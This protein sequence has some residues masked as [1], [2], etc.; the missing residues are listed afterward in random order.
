[1][2]NIVHSS[3]KHPQGRAF[4][5]R[6]AVRLGLNKFSWATHDGRFVKN[7]D[8]SRIDQAMVKAMN[9]IADALEKKTIAEFVEN[10]ESFKMLAAFGVDCAQGYYLGRPD[11]ALTALCPLKNAATRKIS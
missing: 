7:L 11:V 9:E 8:T 6:L 2:T 1:M 5:A 10:E 3:A 4:A